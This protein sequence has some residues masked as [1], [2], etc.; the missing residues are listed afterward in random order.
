M[1]RTK[2]RILRKQKRAHESPEPTTE[3]RRVERTRKY[4]VNRKDSFQE[5]NS[6]NVTMSVP[7]TEEKL[8]DPNTEETGLAVRCFQA[9]WKF[10]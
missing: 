9:Y 3:V 8:G 4:I 5:V 1:Q 2:V 7:N 10:E 6:D